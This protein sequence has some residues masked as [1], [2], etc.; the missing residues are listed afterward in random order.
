M[1]Q[2]QLKCEICHRIFEGKH[3]EDNLKRH[4]KRVHEEII[5]KDFDCK[6]CDKPFT[7]PGAMERHKIVV[8]DGKKEFSCEIC[9]K[10]FFRKSTLK[11]H[12]KNVHEKIKNHECELCD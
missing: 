9:G 12:I 10:D 5:Q 11:L 8:H 3:R 4:V 1:D 6:I 7:S 2:K